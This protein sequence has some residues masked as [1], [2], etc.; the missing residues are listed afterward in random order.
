[1]KDEIFPKIEFETSG[2]VSR[3]VGNK[4]IVWWIGTEVE[5]ITSCSI[6]VRAEIQGRGMVLISLVTVHSEGPDS[7]MAEVQSVAEAILWNT[8]RIWRKEQR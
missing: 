6:E 8:I 7:L 4:P 5:S 1:M 2:S 3:A